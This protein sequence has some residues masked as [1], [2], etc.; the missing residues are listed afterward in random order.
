MFFVKRAPLDG[1]FSFFLLHSDFR[2]SIYQDGSSSRSPMTCHC[3]ILGHRSLDLLAVFFIA[4]VSSLFES[5][6][7]TSP[8]SHFPPNSVLQFPW[9]LPWYLNLVQGHCPGCLNSPRLTLRL[10]TLLA[11]DSNTCT[12]NSNYSSEGKNSIPNLNLSKNSFD[13]SP[14]ILGNCSSFLL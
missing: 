5:P 8:S 7:L 14:I 1:E 13:T 12:F 4:V 10:Q 9:L 2:C 3:Q 11:N 6:S